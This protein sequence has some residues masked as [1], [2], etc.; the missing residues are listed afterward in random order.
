MKSRN[1]YQQIFYVVA[2]AC[3]LTSL[4]LFLQLQ[5]RSAEISQLQGR[6]DHYRVDSSNVEEERRANAYGVRFND[7]EANSQL[8][9]IDSGISMDQFLKQLN[10]PKLVLRFSYLSCDVCVD[11]ALRILKSRNTGFKEEDI[12]LMLTYNNLQD[13]RQFERV[14]RIRFTSALI[15]S[16]THLSEADELNI[17]YFFV[18]LPGQ[19]ALSHIFFPVKENPAR[20][21]EYLHVIKEKYFKN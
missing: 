11:T 8:V 7:L 6:I 20:T 12:R 21:R 19:R 5:S 13:L 17:P 16:N 10:T 15:P 3:L 18:L 2:I 14:N 9:F 4:F 1:I